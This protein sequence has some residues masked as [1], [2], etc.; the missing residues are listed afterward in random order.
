[1]EAQLFQDQPP[2]IPK[3]A[4]FQDLDKIFRSQTAKDND[5]I[6]QMLNIIDPNIAKSRMSVMD[7]LNAASSHLAWKAKHVAST[8]GLNLGG[9]KHPFSFLEPPKKD[10]QYD[11]FTHEMDADATHSKEELEQMQADMKNRKPGYPW[12]FV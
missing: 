1:M 6:T 4:T 10:A 3:N 9:G 8:Y 7:K 11:R 2:S 12:L 5:R